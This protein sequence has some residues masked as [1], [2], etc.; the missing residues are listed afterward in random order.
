MTPELTDLA[1]RAVA[2][3]GWRW[4]PGMMRL[5]LTSP[6]M[7]DYLRKE[8][9]VPDA[10]DDWPYTDWPVIPDLTDPATV[11]CL[12]ALARSAWEVDPIDVVPLVAAIQFPP[13]AHAGYHAW[14]TSLKAAP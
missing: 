3:R 6:D 10:G 11:G 2:S 14:R 13:E 1:Q 5:R 9:R 7:R 4:M 8:G 12:L